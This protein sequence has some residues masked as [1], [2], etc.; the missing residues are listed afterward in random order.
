MSNVPKIVLKHLQSRAEA[1][2][3][4]DMLTAFAERSLPESERAIV[5]DHLSLCGD[6][7]EVVA[8]A[9]PV[10]EAVGVAPL[11]HPARAGWLTMPVLR[12]GVVAA[13]VLAVTS[14]GVLQ[15]RQA[16]PG[17]EKQLAAAV[18]PREPIT[19]T[20]VQTPAAS[21]QTSAPPGVLPHTEEKM[22]FDKRVE[23]RKQFPNLFPQSKSAS[24][25]GATAGEIWRPSRPASHVS[26]GAISGSGGGI[27]SGSGAGLGT[28]APTATVV[29]AQGS[30]P[31]PATNTSVAQVS[32]QLA[33]NKP[34]QFPLQG[35]AVD[36][37]DVA[38]AEVAKAK[39]PVPT[40]AAAM[41]VPSIALHTSPSL[42]QHAAPRWMIT[43]SGSLR[44]SLDAGRTWED[45]NVNSGSIAGS[46]KDASGAVVA[47]A[48][49]TL[50]NLDTAEKR[51]QS[52]G[53]DGL[54]TFANLTPGRYCFD[55][56][57]PGF[58]PLVQS[59]IALDAQ[60]NAR[61]DAALQ[62]GQVSE[63]VEVTSATP[64]Q[65]ETS[66]GSGAE[67]AK[68]NRLKQEKPMQAR[69]NQK[70]W[71]STPNPVFRA[72]AA[73]GPE[74]WAGGSNSV[75]YHSLDAGAHWTRVLPSSA[76]TPLTGDITAVDFSDL[77]HGRV[78]TSAA[79][80]WTTADDGQTWQKQP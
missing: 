51:I 77:Q 18:I 38:K 69:E 63:T 43:S 4:A 57:K 61:L 21:A 49:V 26:A 56:E 28:N 8:L 15:Y 58:K 79:E 65:V 6:C 71:L 72:L 75:L 54:F 12:W 22:Q 62:V 59:P 40:A 68:K 9:L 66:S 5:L 29:E 11:L 1:H 76:G 24:D 36:G 67:N 10:T 17:K 25:A 34:Q 50:T 2:P 80:V 45:V 74:V 20:P 37:S 30:A 60:Q 7:R 35:R 39:D 13:G 32:D 47:D 31:A 52:S 42:M 64:L 41:Q 48:S 46:V 53:S 14:F 70:A 23:A 27:A 19:L 78:T 16:H 33:E 55:V 73:T 3:D 44:R